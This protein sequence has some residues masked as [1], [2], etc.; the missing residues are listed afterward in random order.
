MA[1]QELFRQAADTGCSTPVMEMCRSPVD[2]WQ[3][4]ESSVPVLLSLLRDPRSIPPNT[5]SR[6]VC[7]FVQLLGMNRA[8]Q[9]AVEY[10]KMHG[11][12]SHLFGTVW[13]QSV[14]TRWKAL[15]VAEAAR[16]GLF[17]LAKDTRRDIWAEHG[18]FEA[19]VASPEPAPEFEPFVLP[20]AAKAGHFKC[21][22]WAAEKYG[23][24]EPALILAASEDRV[25][26]LKWLVSNFVDMCMYWN[27][28]IVRAAECPSGT[29]ALR[30][31]L[32]MDGIYKRE[33]IM[34][35][36]LA[37]ASP[38][39]ASLLLA[40]GAT[41]TTG[42]AIMACEAKSSTR[43]SPGPV[44]VFEDGGHRVTMYEDSGTV[45]TS[46]A[47]FLMTYDSVVNEVCEDYIQSAGYLCK[48]YKEHLDK[49]LDLP[50]EPEENRTF[51]KMPPSTFV[52]DIPE[53]F[54]E[55]LL[56]TVMN[57]VSQTELCCATVAGSYPLFLLQQ[58]LRPHETPA[59]R[60]NDMDIWFYTGD[61]KYFVTFVHGLARLS[62]LLQ[63]RGI[64]HTFRKYTSSIFNLTVDG[65]SETLSFIST[66][67]K[68]VARQ[69]DMS[70]CRVEMDVC[71]KRTKCDIYTAIDI[72][73]GMANLLVVGISPIR[74]R[75]NKA[76][77][78]KYSKRGYR[79]I[80]APDRAEWSNEIERRFSRFYVQ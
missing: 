73:F 53:E 51:R 19:M 63:A 14:L 36:A 55:T 27:K 57:L 75:N 25:A 68:N 39:G 29:T 6:Q 48:I 40:A 21:V 42:S 7:V 79:C 11:P 10:V 43:S 80:I 52:C 31:L 60:P 50:D 35:D 16:Q 69:F 24:F 13:P 37:C 56:R 78:V 38:E 67:S 1:L 58:Q 49:V 66:P 9:A 44:I 71:M 72:R 76:R 33:S 47:E 3:L 41:P 17:F 5:W 22:E 32:H 8:A 61:M 15:S 26:V 70:I 2:V 18:H 77:I 30:E 23:V 28:L 62:Q 74:H 46:I 12:C 45:S 4:D 64:G 54:P 65:I 59:W 20:A 34:S